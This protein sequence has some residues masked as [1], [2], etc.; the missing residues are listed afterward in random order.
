MHIVPIILLPLTLKSAESCDLPL[1]AKSE[2]TSRSGGRL[3]STSSLQV[4][5]QVALLF[6]ALNASRWIKVLV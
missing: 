3:N 6:I 1:L 4:L 5:T 2:G